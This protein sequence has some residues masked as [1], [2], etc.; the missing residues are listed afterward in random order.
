M[1]AFG[2]MTGVI[3]N[4][5]IALIKMQGQTLFRPNFVITQEYQEKLE[6]LGFLIVNC[7]QMSPKDL[8]ELLLCAEEIIVQ[9]GSLFF[10]NFPFFSRDAVIYL[11]NNV[12]HHT[13]YIDCVQRNFLHHEVI[14]Y[15][16][17]PLLF[18]AISSRLSQVG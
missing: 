8:L 13:F 12:P 7:E 18:D 5:K 1:N 4:K 11:L 17:I 15:D 9:E 6:A 3:T 2:R 16:S 10:T 14:Y